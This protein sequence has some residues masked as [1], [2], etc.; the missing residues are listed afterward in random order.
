[1]ATLQG[2]IDEAMAR[3]YEDAVRGRLYRHSLT[4]YYRGLALH[5]QYE[6]GWNIGRKERLDKAN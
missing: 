1:M 2:L 6:A 4:P 5:K 3:G